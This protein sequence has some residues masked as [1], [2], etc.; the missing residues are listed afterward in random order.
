MQLETEILFLW[1]E[2]LLIL[3][4]SLI[5]GLIVKKILIN[6]FNYLRKKTEAKIWG[7]LINSTKKW[8][9]PWFVLTG[10][11]IALESW[12]IR[13]NILGIIHKTIFIIVIVSFTF[14][15]SQILSELIVSYE[16]KISSVA[17]IAGL[18][19][20][21]VKVVIF[22]LGA[23]MILHGLGVSITPLLTT[24]GIGGLAIALALQDS[25]KNLVAGM[26]IILAKDIRIGDYIKIEGGEEGYVQDIGWRSTTIR[27]LSNNM[28]IVPNS[29][30]AEAIVINYHLPE[31][32]MSLLIPVSVSYDS[33]PEVIEKI[34]VEEAR[35]AAEDVPGLLSDPEPLAR[36][37][38]GF[39]DYSLDFTLICKVKEYA[40]QYLA[41]SELRKRIFKRFKE[42]GIEIPFPIRTVYVKEKNEES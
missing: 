10:F 27:A 21:I 41:Q 5:I 8:I 31:N 7:I 12:N 28:A 18:T 14:I 38:P 26:H 11:Y 24:M 2:P 39:G 9:I 34:L 37:M 13:P 23:L 1:L 15:I 42:E 33:D 35:K 40:D 16:E 29:R 36:F 4:S 6:Y 17:P 20:N 32:M 3:F 22:L 25:L 19:Q 30:L